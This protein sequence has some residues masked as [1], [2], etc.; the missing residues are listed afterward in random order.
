MATVAVTTEEVRVE[1]GYTPMAIGVRGWA[2][3]DEAADLGRRVDEEVSGRTDVLRFP[4]GRVRVTRTADGPDVTP[5]EIDDGYV[6]LGADDYTL[7]VE[8]TVHALVRFD[9]GVTVSV[10]EERTIL[11]FPERTHVTV[12][13]RPDADDPPG[14]VVV[15]ETPE[16]MATAL[17][18]AAASHRTTTADRSF[19]A[20]RRYP[21]PVEFGERHVPDAVEDARPE[22]D[23]RFVLPP[24]PELLVLSAPLSYYLGAAVR[25]VEGATPRLVTGDWSHEFAPDAPTFESSVASAL[26]RAFRFDCLVRGAGPHGPPVSSVALDRLDVDADALYDATPAERFAAALRVPLDDIDGLPPWHLSLSVE[27]TL[28]NA[29]AL[30]YVIRDVPIFRR[31]VS[32]PL[33]TRDRLS[34]SLD[35]FFRV[36]ATVP[37]IDLVEPE[38]GPGTT[39]G[40]L[41]SGVPV[42][43]YKADVAA[44]RHRFAGRDGDARS[45]AV[46]VVC[47]DESMCDGFEAVVDIYRAA[48]DVSVTVLRDLTTAELAS[49]FEA[50]TDFV[51]F[52]GH[53]DE[54]GLRCSNGA[55]S[56]ATLETVGARAFFLNACG[57]YY[58]GEELVRRGSVAGAVTLEAVLDSPARRV[59]R[60][61]T[62]LLVAGFDVQRAL[63]LARRRIVMS[64]DYTVVGD[65]THT[66]G[67]DDERRPDET[68]IEALGDGNYRVEHVVKSP[69]GAGGQYRS[70]VDDRP[71]L[72]GTR[73]TGTCN[74]EEVRS[75]LSTVSYPVVFEG[76]VWEPEAVR[77]RVGRWF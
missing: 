41:A 8:S 24:D 37:A 15:P 40:W 68:R 10:N 55:L 25:T 28:R 43:V 73:R 56:T 11:A 66:L 50:E 22:T 76:D 58:E 44:Y 71:C 57:S 53:C 46:D 54:G 72:V 64:K 36:G 23:L 21:P 65:G 60:A 30:P 33:S 61:F 74:A 59:S 29:T 26:K 51:H 52:V 7:T 9:A 16:G 34:L 1:T 42:D 69:R 45:V 18:Y 32:E 4:P 35:D 27:P 2:R 48:D 62:R 75:L 19:P 38:T 6:T 39:H 63:Q 14:T 13:F 12:G 17:T 67:G 31:P 20:M 77:E 70:P 49:V 5:R 47:N 3:S